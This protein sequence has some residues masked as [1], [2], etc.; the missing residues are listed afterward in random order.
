MPSSGVIKPKI[1]EDDDQD[2]YIWEATHGMMSH[3]PAV[4]DGDNIFDLGYA[5]DRAMQNYNHYILSRVDVRHVYNENIDTLN[6]DEINDRMNYMAVPFIPNDTSSGK[7]RRL[8]I[9]WEKNF[10]GGTENSIKV[11]IYYL[12]GSGVFYDYDT[13]AGKT[14]Y[15]DTS[16]ILLVSPASGGQW[17]EYLGTYYT[18]WMDLDAGSG[19]HSGTWGD[20]T[21]TGK[22]TLDIQIYY[23]NLGDFFNWQQDSKKADVYYLTELLR[24]A[25][26]IYTISNIYDGA[27]SDYKLVY[28]FDRDGTDSLTADNDPLT[29][30]N[31]DVTG[32][33]HSTGIIQSGVLLDGATNFLSGVIKTQVMSGTDVSFSCWMKYVTAIGTNDTLV[34]TRSGT[35]QTNDQV[36]IRALTNW[37]DG[38]QG[39]VGDG[40]LQTLHAQDFTGGSWFNIIVTASSGTGNYV[41]Y[42]NNDAGTTVASSFTELGLVSGTH[43]FFGRS[44]STLPS[45]VKADTFMLWNRLLTTTERAEI[46]EAGTQFL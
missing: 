16:R 35:D 45:N 31:L 27:L 40:T 11:P 12:L 8:K 32:T 3:F 34:A 41:T 24:P 13:T 30:N 18:S 15:A 29:S 4:I 19:T 37:S 23:G 38:I 10:G 22:S 28:K 7:K 5:L 26:L 44:G 39:M 2:N 9:W 33:V 20:F 42:V 14:D 36:M 1:L 46:Y 25:G 43:M 21:T 6:W 17:G